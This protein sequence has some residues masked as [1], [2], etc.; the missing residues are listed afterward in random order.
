MQRHLVVGA[1]RIALAGVPSAQHAEGAARRRQRPNGAG[2]PRTLWRLV[3]CTE[4]QW[5]AL[6]A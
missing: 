1:L 4:K 6:L 3:W 2:V 5:L